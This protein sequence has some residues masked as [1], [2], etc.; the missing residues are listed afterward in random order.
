[1][2]QQGC[3]SRETEH[4]TGVTLMSMFPGLLIPHHPFHILP[5]SQV[6]M[7]TSWKLVRSW[8]C[9]TW[10]SCSARRPTAAAGAMQQ[11]HWCMPQRWGMYPAAAWWQSR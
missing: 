6:S 7:W 1:M 2:G 8:W 11:L 3:K 5:I 10:P 4:A 9:L